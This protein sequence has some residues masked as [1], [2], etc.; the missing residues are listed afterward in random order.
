MIQRQWSVWCYL[1]VKFCHLR[2]LHAVPQHYSIGLRVQVKYMQSEKKV[3]NV[4]PINEINL[5]FSGLFKQVSL[6]DF[7]KGVPS[8][9]F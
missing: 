7:F 2:Q 1:V 6:I 8:C 9:F 3:I 5:V 4:I